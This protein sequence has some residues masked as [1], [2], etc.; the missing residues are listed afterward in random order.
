MN[1]DIQDIYIEILKQRQ[2]VYAYRRFGNRVM[3]YMAQSSYLG[4][5][6]YLEPKDEP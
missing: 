6:Y 4:S 5:E 3:I 1:P 2:M